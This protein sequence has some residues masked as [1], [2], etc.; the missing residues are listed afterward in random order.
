MFVLVLIQ[1]WNLSAKIAVF[2][3]MSVMTKENPVKCLSAYF[4]EK[5]PMVNC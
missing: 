2:L 1:N 3:I 5:K 4:V